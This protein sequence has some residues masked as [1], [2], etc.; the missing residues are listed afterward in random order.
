MTRVTALRPGTLAGVRVVL[1]DDDALVLEVLAMALEACGASV[2][3]VA[4]ADAAVEAV[5]AGGPHVLVADLGMPHADGYALIRRVRALPPE[6]GG[7]VPAVALT[8]YVR[9][10][11]EVR[12]LEAGYQEHFAKPV[13]AGAL[14]AAIARLT[15]RS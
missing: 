2:T 5:A 10:N 15:G 11:D 3:S 14:A 7:A 4:S 12:A 1:V 9:R 6:A 8:G 13:D